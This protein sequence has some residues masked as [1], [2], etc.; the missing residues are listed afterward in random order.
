MTSQILSRRKEQKE[1][2]TE[3]HEKQTCFDRKWE[4]SI[5]KI[6]SF[7]GSLIQCMKL[8]NQRRSTK[9]IIVSLK[10]ILKRLN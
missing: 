8:Y 2:E 1:D 6:R 10:K 3:R 5:H 7:K 4:I 9:L